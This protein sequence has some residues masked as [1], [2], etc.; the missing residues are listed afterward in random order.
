MAL[1]SCAAMAAV[2][3]GEGGA[4]AAAF[5]AALALDKDA[6]NPSTARRRFCSSTA[7]AS[8]CWPLLSASRSIFPPLAATRLRARGTDQGGQERYTTEVVVPRFRG[9][10]TLLGS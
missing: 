6:S 9:E 2:G 4:A 8:M 5:R 7:G 3:G 10:L 1:T